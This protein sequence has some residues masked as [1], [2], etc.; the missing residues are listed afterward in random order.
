MRHAVRLMAF[1]LGFSLASAFG[2]TP[3]PDPGD[4][5]GGSATV[6]KIPSGCIDLLWWIRY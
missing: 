4:T 3:A 2:S 6:W 1:V 5:A